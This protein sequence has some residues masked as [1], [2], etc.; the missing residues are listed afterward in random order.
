MEEIQPRVIKFLQG[1]SVYLRPI[2]KE[3]AE[4]YYKSLFN[5]EVRRL[6]GT[7]KSFSRTNIDLFIDKIS[8][9]DSRVDL[10]IALQ[11]NDQTVGDIVI[12][13]IDFQNRNANI[14]V[15][16]D[17]SQHFGKGYGSEAMNLM[18]N[19]GFGILNLH[20]IELDVFS[21]NERA[22]RTYEKLGFKKQEGTKRDCL[23]YEYEYHDAII[24]SILAGEFK[25]IHRK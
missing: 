23:Y 18:L 11:D 12:N 16:I 17:N 24:M 15:A 5:A 14:R 20:R 10:I 2:E 25:Q 1:E 21:F 9:D 19:Y 22:I 3:D 4:N 13:D 8:Q 6:T 7:Q